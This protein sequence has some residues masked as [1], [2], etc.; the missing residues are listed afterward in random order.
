[1]QLT[2]VMRILSVMKIYNYFLVLKISIKKLCL[3]LIPAKLR[4]IQY[5][6]LAH[7]TSTV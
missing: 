7:P 4:A 3:L 5:M 6:L 2:D 1:V